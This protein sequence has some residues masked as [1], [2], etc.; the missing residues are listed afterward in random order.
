MPTG[1]VNAP[2]TRDRSSIPEVLGATHCCIYAR[3]VLRKLQP[4]FVEGLFYNLIDHLADVSTVF[5]FFVLRLCRSYYC[6]L[7]CHSLSFGLRNQLR[8]ILF[9]SASHFF[10]RRLMRY[11]QTELSLMLL[12]LRIIL[13]LP[14]T[15][16]LR[17]VRHPRL[18]RRSP[19]DLPF[20]RRDSWLSQRLPFD[21]QLLSCP[22]R[23]CTPATT[24]EADSFA[25]SGQFRPTLGWTPANGWLGSPFSSAFLQGSI[26]ILQLSPRYSGIPLLLS[27]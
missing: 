22:F 24:L 13:R 5:A 19:W 7:A 10:C 25:Q 17:R 11:R 12:S 27:T 26:R 2:S 15:I 18:A 1:N 14:C 23:Q 4:R 21:N 16:A 3:T 8:F 6:H 20:V 9:R